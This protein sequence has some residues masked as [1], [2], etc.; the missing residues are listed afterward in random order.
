MNKILFILQLLAIGLY[1]VKSEG[2]STGSK[3]NNFEY[4]CA[5]IFEKFQIYFVTNKLY[6]SF[7]SF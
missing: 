5:L 7:Y 1:A 6:L 3:L 4:N 2:T